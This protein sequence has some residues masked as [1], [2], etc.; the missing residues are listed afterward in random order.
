MANDEAGKHSGAFKKGKSGNPGGM[1]REIRAKIEA[2]R[3]AALVE[4]PRA[5]ARLAELIDSASAKDAIMASVEILNR[6]CGKPGI[7]TPAAVDEDLAA[8]AELA[9]AKVRELDLIAEVEQMRQ[10]I[11][12]LTRRAAVQ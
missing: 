1:T 11:A 7:G 8:R 9:K 12:E 6:A 5:V 10:Q 2:V 4:A 3:A